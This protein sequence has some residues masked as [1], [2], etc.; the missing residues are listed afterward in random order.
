M[1]P[2][3]Q[4]SSRNVSSV[5]LGALPDAVCPLKTFTVSQYLTHVHFNEPKMFLVHILSILK[6]EICISV[7][8]IDI[9]GRCK[10]NCSKTSPTA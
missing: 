4:T 3:I 10:H 8:S 6:L 7:S 9:P 2:N 1:H 5:L